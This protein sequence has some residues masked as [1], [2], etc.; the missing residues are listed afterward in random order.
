MTSVDIFGRRYNIGGQQSEKT[1]RALARYVDARMGAVSEQAG[2]GDALNVAVIAALN[3]ADDYY[4]A[5]RA[6]ALREEELA[7]QTRALSRRL[8][9]AIESVSE[10]D[11]AL[12]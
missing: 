5:R 11:Q 2:P 9:E 12:E 7:E 1:I 8:G 3:I 4:K 6:L 10:T